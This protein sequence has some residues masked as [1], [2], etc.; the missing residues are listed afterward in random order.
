MV[1]HIAPAFQGC[2]A[3]IT[4]ALVSCFQQ[5]DHLTFLDV[6]AHVE[7]NTYPFQVALWDTHVMLQEVVRSHVLFFESLIV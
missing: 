5:D 6:V 1:R 3:L 7:T 4:P 2:W